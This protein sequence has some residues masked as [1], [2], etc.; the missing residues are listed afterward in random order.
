MKII[1]IKDQSGGGKKGEIKEVSE[2][3]ASNFL[4]PKGFAKVATAEVQAK[5]AKESKEAE[6]KKSKETQKLQDLKA[7]LEKRIFNVSVKVG[8][9]GQIFSGVHEKDI[10]EAINKKMDMNLERRAVELPKPIKELGEHAVKVKLG[11]NIFANIK[12]N[13]EATK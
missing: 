7:D 12:I 5:I 2:G 3:Y 9:K 8:D 11:A 6:A 10:A 1:Y 13:L 4:I